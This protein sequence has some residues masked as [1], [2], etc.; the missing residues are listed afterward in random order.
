MDKLI[1]I[2]TK[3]MGLEEVTKC[4]NNI[5]DSIEDLIRYLNSSNASNN[6]LYKLLLDAGEE[7]G[8]LCNRSAFRYFDDE[9]I[10]IKIIDYRLADEL[11]RLL[12]KTAGELILNVVEIHIDKTFELDS[13]YMKNVL[14]DVKSIMDKILKQI[15]DFESELFNDTIDTV[16]DSEPSYGFLESMKDMEVNDLAD[17][18]DGL[19]KRIIGREKIQDTYMKSKIIKNNKM[20]D[21]EKTTGLVIDIK[22]YRN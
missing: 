18:V 15:G 14:V 6:T 4:Y 19:K 3:S 21:D 20:S 22:E 8:L 1:I 13:N 10:E 16:V 9:E 11:Y 2:K 12:Y 17:I 5:A 7:A